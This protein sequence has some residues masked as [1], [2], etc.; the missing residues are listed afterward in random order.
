ME[1]EKLAKVSKSGQVQMVSEEISK[2]STRWV[3]VLW[4]HKDDA[5]EPTFEEVSA[6]SGSGNT[7]S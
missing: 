2:G 1:D 5:S 7:L 3:L 6:S 4:S